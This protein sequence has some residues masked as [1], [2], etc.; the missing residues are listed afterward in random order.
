[1]KSSVN[2]GKSD[3][4]STSATVKVP[5]HLTD[6]K[7]ARDFGIA[8]KDIRFIRRAGRSFLYTYVDA[9]KE[10][11]RFLKNLFNQDF[12]EFRKADRHSRCEIPDGRGKTKLCPE[13]CHCGTNSNISVRSI[14]FTAISSRCSMMRKR[15]RKSPMLSARTDVPYLMTS[16]RSE[17][18]HSRAV[19][20]KS[21]LHQQNQH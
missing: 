19:C 18:W 17:N 11:E 16:R 10:Q 5:M 2:T 1:M 14:R 12:Q 7:H 9:P 13:T 15:S 21:N 3:N 20:T 6:K 4:P 8:P